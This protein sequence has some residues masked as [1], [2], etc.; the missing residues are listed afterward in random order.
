VSRLRTT[1]LLLTVTLAACTPQT[2]LMMAAVPDGTASVLLGR[3]QRVEDS[4][5][6]KILE[7]ERAHDWEGLARVAE[8]N[9]A[10]DP[11]TPDWQ[12][13][14]GYAYTRLDRHR[15]AA[16]AY[17]EA[18]RMEPDV[19]LGWTLLAGSY[20]AAGE[21]QRAVATLDKA[22]L[23][24][25]DDPRLYVLLGD[26]YMD[27]HH[28]RPA[29]DAYRGAVNVDQALAP[30]WY[31]LTLAYRAAGRADDAQEA[32]RVLGKLDAALAAKAKDVAD[33]R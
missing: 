1:A 29:I 22:L 3:M 31:G 12:I 24:V 26:T 9:I 16:E 5:R 23:A 7:L 20:R 21:P 28:P 11:Y 14:A 8:E 19:A 32:A 33:K 17:A 18:V 4:N 25:R 2:A 15:R 6:R 10:R 13:V 27:M 30:A